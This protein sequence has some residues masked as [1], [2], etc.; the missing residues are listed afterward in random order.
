[1][2]KR[3][4]FTCPYRKKLIVT[5]SVI[6]IF[7]KDILHISLSLALFIYSW[8]LFLCVFFLWTKHPLIQVCVSSINYFKTIF[9]LSWGKSEE[10][11]ERACV[12]ERERERERE[13]KRV[14]KKK[15]F[16]SCFP[17]EYSFWLNK[18]RKWFSRPY[19]AN[20][21]SNQNKFYK[22]HLKRT[23]KLFQRSWKLGIHIFKLVMAGVST[24]SYYS[25]IV[26][27]NV[28][29]IQSKIIE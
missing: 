15:R 18:Y 16:V 14:D 27:I 25:G 13:R 26:S 7:S 3:L 19:R 23:I 1:M 22:Q 11:R 28:I 9:R 21:R 6:V 29:R 17:K 2:S 5:F 10:E 20:S 8:Y 4:Y 24:I 12:W